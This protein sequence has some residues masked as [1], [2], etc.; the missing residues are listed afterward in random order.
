MASQPEIDTPLPGVPEQSAGGYLTLWEHLDEI[1]RRLT[2]AALTIA[3][4]TIVSMVFAMDIIDYLTGPARDADPDFRPIFTELLGF[5][6]AYIKIALLVGI[7]A[8]MPMLLYQLFA[9]VSPGL[10]RQERKWIL[11]I[12]FFGALSF[13][14][15]GAFAFYV[16]WP[17]A[18]DF[19]L[20]FGDSIAD[21]QIRI[22]NYIDMLSR[23]I[24][25]TGVVFETPLVLMGLGVLGIIR[26]RQLVR[27]WR[28]A[29]IGAFVLAALITPSVDPVTQAAVAIPLI[30]LY[31]LG[32]VLVWIVQDRGLN[33]N[34]TD[35]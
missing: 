22:N 14:G 1:R 29:F 35:V 23:F 28:W 25:W 3:L 34:R 8:A 7:A 19:L 26:V 31:V 32:A 15:G 18:L 4:T 33:R 30:L 27:A 9:F 24:F 5:F 13:A 10:T 17:P 2:L 20:N 6:G 11:P 12:V 21:P 16:A